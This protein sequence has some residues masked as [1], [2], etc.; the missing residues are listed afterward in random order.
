VA[1]A[2][3]AKWTHPANTTWLRYWMVLT[4]LRVWRFRVGLLKLLNWFL[5]SLFNLVS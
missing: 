4:W 5:R 3:V 2:L 1:L